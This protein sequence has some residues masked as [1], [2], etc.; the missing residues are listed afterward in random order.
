MALSLRQLLPA[1]KLEN[2]PWPGGDPAAK[3]PWFMSAHQQFDILVINHLGLQH[4]VS[5]DAV[6]ET[7]IKCMIY[8]HIHFHAFH[9]DLTYVA[10]TVDGRQALIPDYQSA[11]CVGAFAQGLSPDQ[12]VSLFN[13]QV[14]EALGYFDEWDESVRLLEQRFTQYGVDFRKFFLRVKRR[15]P[16]MLSTDHPK[17][18]AVTT[19]AARVAIDLL[20]EPES[21]AD[22][23]VYIGDHLSGL[24]W[25]VYPEIGEFYGCRTYYEWEMNGRVMDL[26]G[27]VNAAYAK[28]TELDLK[29]GELSYGRAGFRERLPAAMKG[30]VARNPYRDLEDYRFWSRAVAWPAPG[31]LDPVV[32]SPRIAPADRVV[33]MGSCFAQ[34]LARNLPT[35]GLNHY[36][37]EQPPAGMSAE[38]S[39]RRNYGVFSARYGNLYTMR[40]ALQLFDRAF[41]Q[42]QPRDDVWKTTDGFVDAFRPQIEPVPFATPDEVKAAAAAHLARVR[43]MFESA[44]W[45]IFTLGLTEAWRSRDDGAVYPVAPG[46]A[47]GDFD[48]GVYEFVNLGVNEVRQD[49]DAFVERIRKVNAGCRIILTVSPVPLIATYENRHVLVS[50]VYSKSVLRV[51]AAEAEQ[52]HPHVAY[53]PSFEIITSPAAGNTYFAD[54]LRSVTEIGVRHVM[55]V[56]RK[57]FVQAEK[58]VAAPAPV[59]SV[60]GGPTAPTEVICDEELI[61]ASV[62]AGLA[63][64]IRAEAAARARAGDGAQSA[65]A[66]SLGQRRLGVDAGMGRDQRKGH[67]A[68]CRGAAA[69]TGPARTTLPLVRATVT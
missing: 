20:G 40:Q 30:R 14:F 25:P 9:P 32:T 49:L 48:A 43:L 66:G 19:M 31:Q 24:Y 52:A 29:P 39:Q 53:F 3:L 63:P 7:G 69:T 34:H 42:F 5:L 11:I 46:V 4:I 13:R 61:E 1:D 26:P 18:A 21:L 60:A 10:R 27:Y 55:R 22:R 35:L 45:L 65:A 64:P 2:V 15:S 12:A 6:K 58:T 36:L 16:F 50:T 41:G 54:D 37:F 51:A 23:P 33:T 62:A 56:F 59:H 8:P 44:D 57:H 28:Y 17:I 47:G 38:E 67:A 68:A